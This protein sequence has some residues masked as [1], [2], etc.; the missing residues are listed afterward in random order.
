MRLPIALAGFASAASA[1]SLRQ[2]PPFP[3]PSITNITYW[4]SACPEN[5]LSYSLTSP[6]S[7]STPFTT[8]TSTSMLSF[9][10]SNFAPNFGSFGSS[11][12]MCN[13]VAFLQVQGGWKVVVNGRGT[14]AKGAVELGEGVRL[15][16]RGT[17]MVSRAPWDQ[18]IGMFDVPGP[19]GGPFSQL[20]TPVEGNEKGVETG[21]EGWETELDAE[22]QARAVNET[23]GGFKGEM[24]ATVDAAWTLTT[25][26]EVI[27]C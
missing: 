23:Y 3:A 19:L 17:W 2:A 1:L 8:N 26:V 6:N 15:Y 10:L 27:R 20:L 4:G 16:L 22:F 7:T 12:R 14:T 21:C 11:L 24:E 13:A 9:E 5:G 18:S 25:D